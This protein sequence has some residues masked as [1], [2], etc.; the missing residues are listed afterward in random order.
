LSV[1]EG[2]SGTAADAGVGMV[3]LEI[4]RLASI[5]LLLGED[6]LRFEHDAPPRQMK[7]KNASER[8]C[9]KVHR[10]VWAGAPGLPG[11]EG[12]RGLHGYTLP[13]VLDQ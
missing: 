12:R 3:I 10:D 7:V 2:L 6:G 1:A 4:G 8:S 11:V 9:T 13:G 5:A